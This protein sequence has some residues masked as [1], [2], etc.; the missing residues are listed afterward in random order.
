MTDFVDRVLGRS[1]GAVIRPLLPTLY[2]PMIRSRVEE[3]L[4]MG[5]FTDAVD[6]RT[7]TESSVVQGLPEI[8]PPVTVPAAPHAAPPQPAVAIPLTP[9]GQAEPLP[10]AAPHQSTSVVSVSPAS[11][12][13][14]RS[15]VPVDRRAPHEDSRAA[16]PVPGPSAVA[17]SS[18]VQPAQ[19]ARPAVPAAPEGRFRER[20]NAFQ[21]TFVHERDRVREPDVH[22]SIGRVEIK[23]A[24]PAAQPQRRVEPGRRPQL[25]LDDYLKS[26]GS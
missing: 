2:E 26:R 10:T 24:M 19:P 18:S 8:A 23:A 15:A 20:P 25:T 3:P 14:R 7:D 11:P 6:H 17:E 9:P 16:G 12:H 5:T 1:A 13:L 21:Q 4:P 22:I